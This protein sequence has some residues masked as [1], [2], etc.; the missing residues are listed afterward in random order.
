MLLG[1]NAWLIFAQ[2]MH[3]RFSPAV[4][5]FVYRVFYI[6]FSPLNKPKTAFFS[7]N[8]YNVFS[9]HNKDYGLKDGSDPVLWLKNIFQ[10]HNITVENIY[11]LTHPRIFGYVFNPVSFWFGINDKSEIIAV[12]AEVNNT[13]GEHHCY[14]LFNPDFSP[15]NKQQQ[16]TAIKQFHVSPFFAVDGE[17]KFNFVI[18]ANKINIAIDYFQQQKMLATTVNSYKINHFSN[19]NLL[20]ALLSMPLMFIKVITLIHWQAIKILAKSIKYI[21]KPP[22]QPNKTTISK[23]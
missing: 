6:F 1:N 15:I 4:N 18:E 16:L 12:V 20:K 10:Q 5:F 9:F 3:K 21:K 8:K 19:K 7:Y 14:L 13:F 22:Q 11:L 2:V 23:Q 17:Y